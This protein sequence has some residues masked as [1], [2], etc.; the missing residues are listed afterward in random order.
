MRADWYTMFSE[1][2]GVEPEDTEAA[3]ANVWL[4]AQG[5]SPLAGK[6][7]LGARIS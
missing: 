4:K 2:A 5:L 7:G 3:K 6:W 1:L